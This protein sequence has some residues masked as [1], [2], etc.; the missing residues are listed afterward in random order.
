MFTSPLAS[1]AGWSWIATVA[2]DLPKPL[3]QC[4]PPSG[5]GPPGTPAAPESA[6]GAI[7]GSGSPTVLR[8]PA[9]GR[10]HHHQEET[11]S[12]HWIWGRA[13]DLALFAPLRTRLAL[14]N[15]VI[16]IRFEDGTDAHDFK[17]DAKGD[18][19]EDTVELDGNAILTSAIMV[20]AFTPGAPG[21][22]SIGVLR[23]LRGALAD[24]T[25]FSGTPTWQDF[26]DTLDGIEQPLRILEPGGS[27]VTGLAIALDG[28]SPITLVP[29][30]RGDVFAALGI[31]RA[32]LIAGSTLDV[33]GGGQVAATSA[34]SPFPDGNVPLS[35]ETAHVT[36]APLTAWLSPQQSPALAR[37]TRGNTVTPFAD[38]L[39]TF[40]DLFTE[41]DG[42]VAAGA[43]GAFYV[44]GYSLHHEARLGPPGLTHRTVAEVTQ[45]MVAAGG[46]PR[47]LALQMLQLDPD[48]VR[49]VQTSVALISVLLA[50]GAAGATFFQ[51]ETSWDQPNF[52]LHTQLIAAGLL[53][54]SA[55]LD[56][57]IDRFEINRGAIDALSAMTG[58]EAHLDP[59]D[60]EV[61]DNPHADPIAGLVALA[62]NAQRRFN[63]FHQKVQIVR[64]TDGVHAYC[65]GIDLNPNRLQ[66][67][68]HASR[69]P[70]HDVHAR[71]NG[72]A[73]GEL[74]TTFRERWDR[75]SG[76]PL[77]LDGA[78]LVGLPTDGSDIV[79]VARTYHGSLPGS[80]RGFADFA[81]NGERTVLDTLLQAIGQAR[82]YIYIEDQ[83]LTPPPEFA[84]ALAAAAR[85]V[86]GPLVVLVPATPDQ[87]FGL[88]RRQQFI[89]QMS[90]AWGDRFR[91]GILRKRF[92]KTETS[93]R[94]A[95]GRLWLAADLVEADNVIE[96]G[97]PARLPPAPF[98]L[99]VGSEV[100]RAY[101]KVAGFSSP[102]SDR[103]DVDRAGDTNLFK[104]NSGTG[105][106]SHKE[107]AAV[108][109]GTFPSIYV[110]SKMML[111]DDAFASIGS[112]NLNRR[113]FF[114]DGECNLFALRETLAEG[115]DNWIRDLRLALWAEHLGVTEAYGSV[116]LLDPVAC[117]PLFDRK[118]TTGNRF[119]PFGAQPYTTDLELQ[120]EF[121][122]TTGTLGG[123][124]MIAELTAAMAVMI[125]GA[126][127][128]AIFDTII[129]PGSQVG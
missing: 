34:G 111:I 47:F 110:H 72:G 61:D 33:T 114:S 21:L 17:G 25:V 24:A 50:V 104:L 93:F 127:A 44:T 42:A 28:G 125:A 58:V 118:F 66:D 107:G 77:V 9:S 15:P 67:R 54:G 97:P 53:L 36:V 123:I 78:Q 82:R 51:D 108:A 70:Y 7:A 32:D 113:G 115:D 14:G 59:V 121:T 26:V 96:L 92:L 106:S 102:T 35:P 2:T 129:D 74:I 87:P 4:F 11:S 52:F 90:A 18:A 89:Q 103:F 8:F 94:A 48:W 83:Y 37:F 40:A 85:R 84:S 99:V 124:K 43:D 80:G 73:A 56:S 13:A 19:R 55:S 88:A 95:H 98:W 86:S 100:M 75:T 46:Q 60:A 45:A 22:D 105:R 128:D 64:N 71:V 31:G 120:T 29:A 3:R 91:V 76:T 81:P 57:L 79:Q 41:L 27:P 39:A 65:G 30:H 62:L 10:W 119:T 112:A 126:E 20:V 109:T 63:V 16:A 122:D 117:L 38:G 12:V 116:A 23:Y 6:P 5:P 49:D 1:L 68:D 101:R 69:S